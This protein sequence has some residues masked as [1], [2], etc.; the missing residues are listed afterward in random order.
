[1]R[2]LSLLI[3]FASVL[4]NAQSPLTLN[5][6][7]SIVKSEYEALL[8]KHS[9][10]VISSLD[11]V[12]H[13]PVA[14]LALFAKEGKYGLMNTQGEIITK[15]LYRSIK[16]L[17]PFYHPQ[18]ESYKYRYYLVELDSKYG[19]IDLSG[20]EIIPLVHSYL[21]YHGGDSILLSRDEGE[22]VVSNGKVLPYVRPEE[23]R[24]IPTIDDREHETQDAYRDYTVKSAYGSHKITFRRSKQSHIVKNYGKIIK[25]YADKWV[26][27]KGHNGLK[28]VYSIPLKKMIV[29]IEHAVV[30]P[31][32]SG[33]IVGDN[34]G[35]YGVYDTLGVL[36]IPLDKGFVTFFGGPALSG[37]AY[38][39]RIFDENGKMIPREYEVTIYDQN[40]KK[41]TKNTYQQVSR[42]STEYIIAKR[43]DKWGAFD[44]HGKRL[45]KFKYESLQLIDDIGLE[46]PIYKIK[47]KGK[48]GMLNAKGKVICKA[49]YD[50]ISAEYDIE[51]GIGFSFQDDKLNYISAFSYSNSP[52]KYFF[53]RLDGKYGLMDNDFKVIMK[54]QYEVLGKSPLDHHLYFSENHKQ[55]ILDLNTQEVLVPAFY[56][57]IEYKYA[58]GYYVRKDKKYGLL[59]KECE[60]VVP[61]TR[62]QSFEMTKLFKGLWIGL[63]YRQSSGFYVNPYN[64]VIEP[65]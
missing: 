41:V 14:V 7:G 51:D 40:F 13:K 23:V 2:F 35:T 21:R 65:E 50:Q 19:L 62:V 45:V 44:I 32:A 1:M 48:V 63:A 31:K 29:P 54:H 42:Y 37:F 27:F 55:G 17:I 56:S 60:I 30:T 58:K 22:L 9:I 34:Y 49:K 10:Q 16:G 28:G 38:S 64:E 36:Q 11:T 20:N 53:Y 59:N 25:T 52:N 3:L 12:Y 26:I 4:V 24:E 5:A 6:D 18:R 43:D 57:R 61:A 33:I 47:L 15:Q 39:K 46:E 8:A